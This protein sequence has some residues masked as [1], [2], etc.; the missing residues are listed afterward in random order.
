M[1]YNF[2]SM[3]TNK[4]HAVTKWFGLPNECLFAQFHSWK[5]LGPLIIC[6]ITKINYT[7]LAVM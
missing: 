1:H 4:F 3:I 2:G 6:P 7:E 5:R